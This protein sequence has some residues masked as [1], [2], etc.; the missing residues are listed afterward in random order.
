ME[1][2]HKFD[3]ELLLDLTNMARSSFY[4][5]KQSKLPDKYEEIK[6]LEDLVIDLPRL[7]QV[8]YLFLF[9]CYTGLAYADLEKAKEIDLVIEEDQIFRAIEIKWNRNARAR[10]SKSFSRNYE[11]HTFEVITPD[12]IEEVLL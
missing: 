1:L 9:C 5:Q 11:N 2:R 7:Q 6:K 4:Y 8:K 12:N 3:L 10:L